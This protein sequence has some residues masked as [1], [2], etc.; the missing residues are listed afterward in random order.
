MKEYRH[1]ESSYTTYGFN[2]T[3]HGTAIIMIDDARMTMHYE[4]ILGCSEEWRGEFNDDEYH[5]IQIE[6]G[7]P[8]GKRADLKLIG[9][10]L[11]FG[12]WVTD[13]Y[14]GEWNIVLK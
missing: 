13:D 5:L 11:L 3:I 12:T 2:K 10:R 1:C 6:G 7:H 8:T 9:G 4:D 14:S